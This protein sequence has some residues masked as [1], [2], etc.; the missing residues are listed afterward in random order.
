MPARLLAS[1]EGTS[2]RCST[3]LARTPVTAQKGG[4]GVCSWASEGGGKT[5]PAQVATA[6][7]RHA[8]RVINFPPLRPDSAQMAP[9]DCDLVMAP[10]A[11]NQGGGTTIRSLDLPSFRRRA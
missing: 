11:R 5:R 7:V 10:T 8:A 2:R 9:Q 1:A 3:S 4:L 6:A